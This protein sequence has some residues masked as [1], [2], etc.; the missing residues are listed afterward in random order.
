V[1]PSRRRAL[2]LDKAYLHIVRHQS[3]IDGR[4]ASIAPVT[5][6]LRAVDDGAVPLAA[7]RRHFGW[8][9]RLDWGLTT[10]R[11]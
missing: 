2:D 1:T 10:G 5:N 3:F 11:E 9:I 8:D 4:D 6:V 7:E